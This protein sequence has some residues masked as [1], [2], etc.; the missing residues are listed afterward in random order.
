[1][2]TPADTL[3]ASTLREFRL[4]ADGRLELDSNADCCDDLDSWFQ[5]QVHHPVGVPRMNHEAIKVEGGK[6]YRHATGSEIFHVAC[7]FE[8]EPVSLFVCVGPNIKTADGPACSCCN[9]AVVTRGDD[10]TM[11]T[12][13]KGEVV[14]VLVSSMDVHQMQKMFSFIE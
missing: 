12:W 4:L 9:R 2:F 3:A 14:F 5:A 7:R 8:G 13:R 1:M 11:L 6:L 10:Y